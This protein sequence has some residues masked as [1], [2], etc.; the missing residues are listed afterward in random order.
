MQTKFNVDMTCGG[1]ENA[2]KRV[3]KKIRGV[4]KIDTNVETKL[5]TVD[6]TNTVTSQQILDALKKW[7]DASGKS[8]ELKEK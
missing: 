6:H 2:V 5:V 8:V 7:A 1:C 3:L 4:T